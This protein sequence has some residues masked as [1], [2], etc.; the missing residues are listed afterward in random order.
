MQDIPEF[1]N[2]NQINNG[3]QTESDNIPPLSP[4]I[5]SNEAENAE[6]IGE[7][8]NNVNNFNNF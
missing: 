6:K 4:E 3:F 8:K 7:N 5:S 2:S 1:E